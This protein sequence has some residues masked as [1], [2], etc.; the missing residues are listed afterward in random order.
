M[1]Q[2]S[3]TKVGKGRHFTGIFLYPVSYIFTV[4]VKDLTLCATAGTPGA[5][6]L[7]IVTFLL[8]LHDSEP[9]QRGVALAAKCP[10]MMGVLLTYHQSLS[11]LA[12]V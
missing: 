6:S 9:S 4:P 11:S 10:F 7:H 5:K 3:L 12:E 8:W 1:L 2:S